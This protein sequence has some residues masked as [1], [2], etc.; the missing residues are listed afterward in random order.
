[1]K[2]IC[3]ESQPILSRAGFA[4]LLAA[5]LLPFSAWA[6]PTFTIPAELWEQPRSARVVLAQPVLR[7][8]VGAWLAQPDAL[9]KLHHG[10]GEEVQLRAEELRG[11]LAALSVEPSRI[12]LSGD[13]P[14]SEEIRI[15]VTLSL[16]RGTK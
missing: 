5:L 12:E 8:A 3:L 6:G 14:G 7:Q 4:G 15:E 13:L 1:M 16:L 11:W 10:N 9:L 2:P